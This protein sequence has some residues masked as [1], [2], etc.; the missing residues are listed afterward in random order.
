[1]AGTH[2][3]EIAATFDAAAA[4]F[5]LVAPD[6]WGPAGQALVFQARLSPGDTVL[7]VGSGTGA[8]ALPAA[9]AVGPT[10]LVHAVDLS[11]EMLE[12]GR[13]KA[14]DRALLNIEFVCAD[15]TTWEPPS[16]V[17]DVGYDALLSSYA[18][19]FLPEMD[20]AFARLCGLV[21]PGGTVGVTAWQDTALREYATTFLDALG[22][23]L[24]EPL[25]DRTTEMEPA[26][27]ID[28]TDKLGAWLTD[29]GTE[30]VEVRALS[31]L[32]PATEEFCWNFVL[33]SGLRAT[34]TGLA[35][36]VVDRVRREFMNLITDRELHTVDATTLVGTAKVVG[37]P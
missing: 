32:I 8:S 6:V 10:G 2:A 28:S 22:R 7:D 33:G 14:S 24:P 19:F 17:P 3:E 37:F 25:P 31:N 30:A 12:R 35:P 36:D 11:D 27:R 4:D 23:H 1:M 21:R 9:L 16:T 34:L 18:V 15:A 5:D 20:Q 29:A 26:Q 13:V